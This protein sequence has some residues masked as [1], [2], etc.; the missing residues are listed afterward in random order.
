MAKQYLR[1][2]KRDTL[3]QLVDIGLLR[4]K[5]SYSMGSHFVPALYDQIKLDV[6]EEQE[7]QQVIQETLQ[8]SMADRATRHK[9]AIKAEMQRREDLKNEKRLAEEAAARAK[10]RRRERRMC[11]KEQKRILELQDVLQLT[12][13][14]ACELKEY[15]V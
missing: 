14:P 11:L 13:V 1:F 4:S 10:E 9:A 5:K 6:I 15:S 8:S 7:Q 2:F 12:V 3:Q